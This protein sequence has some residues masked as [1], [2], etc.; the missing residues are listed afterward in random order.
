MGRAAGQ[1]HLRGEDTVAGVQFSRCSEEV[2]VKTGSRDSAGDTLDRKS[3][4]TEQRL[5]RR[6]RSIAV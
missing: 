5:G 6:W 3:G 2:E 1:T 4:W